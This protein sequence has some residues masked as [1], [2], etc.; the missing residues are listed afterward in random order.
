M[1]NDVTV[2]YSG[3][4]STYAERVNALL[5]GSPIPLWDAAA[6]GNIPKAGGIYRLYFADAPDVTLYVG[7]SSNLRK[8]ICGD[9][10]AGDER[11]HTFRSKLEEAYRLNGRSDVR[12]FM[13]RNI[14]CQVLV[15]RDSEEHRFIE[16]FTIAVLR[17]KMNDEGRMD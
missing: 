8:R 10:L 12:D 11:S 2:D 1:S 16:H 17:P 3:E 13:E 5:G 7:R 9:L 6:Q 4:L 15:V 14:E